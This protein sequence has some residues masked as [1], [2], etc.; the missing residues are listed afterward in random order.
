VVLRDVLTGERRELPPASEIGA[1]LEVADG[2]STVGEG[3]RA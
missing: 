1:P 2:G 3:S